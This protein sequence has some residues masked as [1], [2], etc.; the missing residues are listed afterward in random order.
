MN[1][2]DFLKGIA[3]AGIGGALVFQGL[4]KFGVEAADMVP[5]RKAAGQTLGNG[6]RC[7]QVS[8]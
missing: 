3:A 6:H 7:K 4:D 5:T 8:N 2:R 1:R